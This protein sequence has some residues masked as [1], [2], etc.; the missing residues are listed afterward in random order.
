MERMEKLEWGRIGFM[1]RIWEFGE[2][3]PDCGRPA[4]CMRGILLAPRTGTKQNCGHGNL[5]F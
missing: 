5:R 2:S 3:T 1:G 4:D